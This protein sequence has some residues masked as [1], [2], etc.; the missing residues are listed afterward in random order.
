MCGK[1][2]IRSG[3]LRRAA[4]A[5]AV[6]AAILYTEMWRRERAPQLLEL[7]LL[8]TGAPVI[9][10]LDARGGI[11]RLLRAR[12]ANRLVR[13]QVDVGS[14]SAELSVDIAR[15]RRPPHREATRQSAS[16]TSRPC[17]PSGSRMVPSGS[18][19]RSRTPLASSTAF[20]NA[21]S[22]WLAGL[23]SAG[24]ELAGIADE[25]EP[26]RPL[27]ARHRLTGD[28][29]ALFMNRVVRA[30]AA[31]LAQ[32]RLPPSFVYQRH[33]AFLVAGAHVASDLAVPL[34]LEWNCS[35]AWTRTHW[36]A[37][38]RPGRLLNGVLADLERRLL[39]SP[40]THPI[41]VS[42]HAARM[43]AEVGAPA[44]RIAVVPN[45]VD[46]SA[47]R[48][49]VQNVSRPPSRHTG[50]T[51]LGWI[52]SFG[53]WHGADTMIRAL[54]LL[55]TGIRLV[56]IGEGRLRQRCMELANDLD[57]Q[58]RIEWTGAMTHDEAIRRLAASDVLVSPHLQLE[59]TPFFG[60][61]TK[62]FEY[63]AIGGRSSRV[64]SRTARGGAERRR[65][66]DARNSW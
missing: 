30:G 45:G 39:R 1:A 52:G 57:V 50:D 28:T 15:L 49:A 12:V 22:N 62:L 16:V 41:A 33:E 19:G 54:A 26:L 60:S 58:E 42:E 4:R 25:F 65:Q 43:A 56:M 61:P 36:D 2:E 48:R 27:P 9:Y 10:R 46:F 3:S 21:A 18:V 8:M 55:P 53:P 20:A 66:R 31:R 17:S 37:P 6:D 11:T 34:T 47:V 24:I 35:V 38:G 40:W 51:E 29:E 7:G 44:E 13:I 32:Y 59:D 5:A 14:I 63:L 64:R 23:G